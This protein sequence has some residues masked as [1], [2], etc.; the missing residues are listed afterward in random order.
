MHFLFIY[1]SPGVLGGIE[2]LLTRMSRWLCE[3]GHQVTLLVER[4]GKWTELLSPDVR[5]IALDRRFRELYYYWHA[6]QLWNSLGISRPDVVKSFD[7]PSSW[8]A[9]Q[10]AALTGNGCKVLAGIYNPMVFRWYYSS[11]SLP[12]W[13]DNL[14]YLRNYLKRIPPEARIFCGA[15]QVEELEEIH[16]EKGVLWPIPIDTTQF[17]PA[18]RRPE[19][20][21]IVSIGRLSP[22]KEYNLYMIDIVKALRE[23]GRQ[24]TW[25][26]YGAGEYENEMRKRIK[27]NGLEPYVFLKGAIPYARFWKVLEEAYI[28]VGMGTSILEAALFKVPNVSANAY[29]QEGL[30]WGPVYAFPTGSIGAGNAPAKLRVIDEIERILDLDPEAYCGEENRVGSSVATHEMDNSMKRFLQLASDTKPFRPNRFLY[31]SNY[32]LWFLRRAMK[33]LTRSRQTGHPMLV[34]PATPANT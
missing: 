21:K 19:W 29:D 4:S 12:R 6:R 20:G 31:M 15:D 13:D 22:M 18:S 1:P 25:T 26:V 28:F 17:L 33:K 30:T 16:R 7:L 3:D 32:P 11:N 34:P 9:C 14:L 8:M 2:T 24:V 27:G 23:K 10:L 5:C